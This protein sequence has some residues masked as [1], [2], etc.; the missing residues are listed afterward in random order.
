MVTG[1]VVAPS[2]I[3]TLSPL[4]SAKNVKVVALTPLNSTDV[5]CFASSKL[6]P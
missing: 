4:R 2:G 5:V 6:F 1:P 3:F